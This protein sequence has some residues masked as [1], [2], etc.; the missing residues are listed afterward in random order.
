MKTYLENLKIAEAALA[1]AVAGLKLGYGNDYRHTRMALASVRQ[2]IE[3]EET[4]G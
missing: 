1:E 3:H 4:F 2:A